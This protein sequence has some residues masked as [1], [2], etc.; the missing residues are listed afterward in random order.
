ML[1]LSIAIC[2]ALSCIG[3]ARA[4]DVN[5][6][7]LAIGASAPDFTLKGVDD[8]DH[9][10]KDFAGSKVLVIVFTVWA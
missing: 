8:K 2:I 4:D 7:T 6:P 10:L 1:R 3:T 9:S 5:P